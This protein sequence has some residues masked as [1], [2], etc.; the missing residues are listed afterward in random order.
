MKKI[1]IF[2]LSV[3]LLSASCEKE[4]AI[5][6]SDYVIFGRIL[7]DA[8]DYIQTF[9]Y[10][11]GQLYEDDMPNA[12][13]VTRFKSTPIDAKKLEKVQWLMSDLSWINTM[14]GISN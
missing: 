14:Q 2:L 1:F 5:A 11:N 3:C 4:N 7:G 9:K 13:K 12:D 10:E 6:A 8:T